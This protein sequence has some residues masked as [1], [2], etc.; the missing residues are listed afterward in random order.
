MYIYCLS[1]KVDCQ[2]SVLDEV[3]WIQYFVI[4]T[5]FE[6]AKGGNQKSYTKE[7]QAIKWPKGQTITQNTTY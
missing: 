1:F 5:K 2:I 6:D 4:K 3:H 7:G